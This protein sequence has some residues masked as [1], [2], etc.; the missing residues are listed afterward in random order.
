MHYLHRPWLA[1]AAAAGIVLGW[2]VA[3]PSP[4]PSAV[5]YQDAPPAGRTGAPGET[6]CASCHSGG[7]NDGQ[8]TLTLTGIP[9]S[10]VPGTKYSV[11]VTLGRTGQSRWGFEVT[12]LR[13]SDDAMAGT[14][15]APSNLTQ[16]LTK[17]SRSYVSHISGSG[18]DGTFAGTANGP[19]SWTFDWTAPAAGT[20]AVTFYLVGVAADND[21]ND[22]SGDRVYTTTVSFAEASTTAVRQTTWAWIKANYR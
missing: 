22:G 18:P 6:T 10:Y 8:G 12:S 3:T 19:V 1:S 15:A 5:M 2:L 4:A 11:T 20:G 17:T 13:D 9:S 14:L 16:I 21:G 7:L